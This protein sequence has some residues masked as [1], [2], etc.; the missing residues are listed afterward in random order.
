MNNKKPDFQRMFFDLYYEKF[1]FLRIGQIIAN[2]HNNDSTAIFYASNDGLWMTM[3]YYLKELE[4]D[5]YCELQ[6]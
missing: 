4:K 5:G 2:S 1:T 3:Y 6:M